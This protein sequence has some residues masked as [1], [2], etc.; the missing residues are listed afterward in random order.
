MTQRKTETRRRNMAQRTELVI[1]VVLLLISFLHLLRLLNGTEI[2][3]GGSVIPIWTSIFGCVGPAL[4]A[5]L[6]WWSHKNQ[7]A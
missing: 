6:F 7:G 2:S 4:L 1:I 5:F 3:I